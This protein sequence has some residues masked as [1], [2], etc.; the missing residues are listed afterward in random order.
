MN[1]V[2]ERKKI[3]SDI[4]H[5]VEKQIDRFIV[6]RQKPKFN[7]Y[8][9][10]SSENIDKKTILEFSENK[11]IESTY[12]EVHKAYKREDEYL[13]EA[14]G[15]YRKTQLRE[16]LEFLA[17]IINDLKQYIIE[18]SV[19]KPRK[20]KQIDP[21]K[22]VAKVSY[23]SSINIFGTEYASINPKDILGKKIL[24]MI[25][26][27]NN[28]L[29]VIHSEGIQIKGTTIINVDKEKSWSKRIRNH[30][31]IIDHINNNSQLVLKNLFNQLKTTPIEV[32]GRINSNCLLIKAI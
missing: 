8:K 24:Y 30:K 17:G 1:I 25:D 29:I 26:T 28:K 14:Y 12:E 27:K 3:V 4:Q 19:R 10:L 9:F 18:K 16:F 13:V 2:E 20:K 5:I 15:N 6:E 7:F 22:V 23:C 31:Q 11:F 32:T 21:E